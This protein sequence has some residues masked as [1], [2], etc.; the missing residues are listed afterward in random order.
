MKKLIALL[1]IILLYP[2]LSMALP[3]TYPLDIPV[4]M[5]VPWYIEIVPVGPIVL[6]QEGGSLGRSFQG[7]SKLQFACNFNFYLKCEIKDMLFAGNWKCWFQNPGNLINWPG[8]TTELYIRVDKA[9]L[10]D[11]DLMGMSGKQIQVALLDIT[12]IPR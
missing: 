7:F 2:A 3:P 11:P 10:L 1:T 12:I 4:K 8:G 5:V 9:D 6:A